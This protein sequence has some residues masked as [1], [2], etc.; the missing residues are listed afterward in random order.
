M[1]SGIIANPE[2]ADLTIFT[3]TREMKGAEMEVLISGAIGVI[4]ALAFAYCVEKIKGN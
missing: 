4:V 2:P 3:S 1:L